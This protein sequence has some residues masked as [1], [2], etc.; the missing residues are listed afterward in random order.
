MVNRFDR[1]Y[2]HIKGNRIADIPRTGSMDDVERALN[3]AELVR[4]WN[5]FEDGGL[6]EALMGLYNDCR[7]Q[8]ADEQRQIA[9]QKC[10]VAIEA[11]K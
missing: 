5:A 9:M 1:L 8:H 3:A 6:V 2:I 11:E 10:F 7:N 4:C